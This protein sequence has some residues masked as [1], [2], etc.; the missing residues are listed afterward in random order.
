[1][2]LCIVPSF[3]PSSS[4]SDQ[5]SAAVLASLINNLNNTDHNGDRA[6]WILYF[7]MSSVKGSKIFLE[8]YGDLYLM[9]IS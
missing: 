4:A 6:A 5:F 3:N 9:L 2:N 1:V 7:K 8:L